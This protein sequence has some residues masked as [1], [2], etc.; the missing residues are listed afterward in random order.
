MTETEAAECV[1]LLSAAYGPPEEAQEILWLNILVT[2]DHQRGRA[3]VE[4]WTMNER[5]WPTPADINGLVQDSRRRAEMAY[6]PRQISAGTPMPPEEGLAVA[7]RAY[8]IEVQRVHG[9][10][11]KPFE[12]FC[13][14]LPGGLRF[15]GARR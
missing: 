1:M 12:Q 5:F 9:R 15:T 7:Y 2:T 11:P 6:T 14:A 10:E 13:K 3:A 8:C 4:H